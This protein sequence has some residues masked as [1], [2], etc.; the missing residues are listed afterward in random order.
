MNRT[1]NLLTLDTSTAKVNVMNRTDNLLTLDSS[2]AKVNVMN[3][4]GF[5]T[6]PNRKRP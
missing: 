4:F 3:L 5:P 1:D 2:T 6:A